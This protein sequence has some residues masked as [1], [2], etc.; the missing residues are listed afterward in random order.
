MKYQ[1][2]GLINDLHRSLKLKYFAIDAGH[3]VNI[4]VCRIIGSLGLCL[5][6]GGVSILYVVTIHRSQIIV[7]FEP[8]R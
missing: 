7:K 4:N 8:I 1:G 6:D 2:V 5:L 3:T